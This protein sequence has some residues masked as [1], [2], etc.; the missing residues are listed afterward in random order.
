MERCTIFLKLHELQNSILL[1]IQMAAEI[2]YL[3]RR[4]RAAARLITNFNAVS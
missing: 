1:E 3:T 2:S 4:E